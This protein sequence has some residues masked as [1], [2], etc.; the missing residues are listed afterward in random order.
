MVSKTKKSTKA[1]APAHKP[2]AKKDEFWSTV[3]TIVYAVL[4]ALLLR[5]FFMQPFSIPSRSMVPSLLVGDYLFVTKYSYGYSRYSFPLSLP[6]FK[7]RLFD[8]E[9]TRGDIVVF[10]HPRQPNVDYIKRVIGLPGDQ[11]QVVDGRLY[12]NRK[13]VLRKQAGQY[14][15]DAGSRTVAV[16]QFQET[17]DSGKVFNTI[18]V[19]SLPIADDTPVFE[20]PADHYFFMGDNR[21]N[22][23]D[24]R[25]P[26]LG[27]VHKDYL[28][29]HAAFIFFSLNDAHF[30]EIWKWPKAIRGDRLFK[31]I[32]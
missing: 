4:L 17:L 30:W 26:E 10:R 13:A 16:P 6:L 29:G 2:E 22:S 19:A 8:H 23:Q 28:I 9:P 32:N 18:D 1:E 24:S 20:V 11:I 27:F 5:S 3:K 7:G 31:K 14:L 15:Y 25:F 12:I 21:D